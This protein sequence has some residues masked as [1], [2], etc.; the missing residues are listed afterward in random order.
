MLVVIL[1]VQT[2]VG[3]SLIV[4]VNEHEASGAQPL[5]AVHVTV[6]VP[7]AN[8]DPEAGEQVTVAAGIPAVAVGLVHVATWLSHCVMLAGQALIDGGVQMKV[9]VTL[10]LHDPVPQE[11]VS[12]QVTAVV[13]IAKL[14]PDAGEQ[15]ADAAGVPV[16]AGE[17]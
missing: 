11:F 8:V 12:V 15:V 6:D 5:E 7:V 2:G 14:L 13:P 9:T 17:V 10:K 16:A 4:T 3:V 1:P